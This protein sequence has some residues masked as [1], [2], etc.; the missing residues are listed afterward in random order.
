MRCLTKMRNVQRVLRRPVLQMILQKTKERTTSHQKIGRE[1]VATLRNFGSKRQISM[2]LV[3]EW[4]CSKNKWMKRDS[5]KGLSRNYF[6]TRMPWSSWR[7]AST[8]RL[9]GPKTLWSCVML[10]T[11]NSASLTS[12][13]LSQSDAKSIAINSSIENQNSWEMCTSGGL[14]ETCDCKI[15]LSW[16]IRW[17]LVSCCKCVIIVGPHLRKLELRSKAA[18]V[19]PHLQVHHIHQ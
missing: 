1:P 16:H 11:R 13:V 6:M 10:R 2:D 3:R 5:S 7:L 15:V 9:L 17:I 12:C 14:S 8:K 4:P 18:G 19:P